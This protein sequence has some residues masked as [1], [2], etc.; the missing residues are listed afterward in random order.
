M[1]TPARRPHHALWDSAKSTATGNKTLGPGPCSIATISR[2]ALARWLVWL[3][4][5]RSCRSPAG[6]LEASGEPNYLTLTFCR[7][8]DWS[9]PENKWF[10]STTHF[11]HRC[12]VLWTWLAFTWFWVSPQAVS[13]L[14]EI[15]PHVP[16]I[17]H[18]SPFNHLSKPTPAPGSI[19]NLQVERVPQIL[20]LTKYN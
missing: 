15:S 8:R 16:V 1:V 3:W 17:C 4:E 11:C 9:P 10:L 13:C 6:I 14:P 20:L 7:E 18:Q 5:R 2:Q 12:P 19:I